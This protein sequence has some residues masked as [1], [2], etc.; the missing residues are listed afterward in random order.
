MYFILIVYVLGV[1]E[2]T[3]VLYAVI[4]ILSKQRFTVLIVKIKSKK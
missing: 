1:I 4:E 3:A 2:E